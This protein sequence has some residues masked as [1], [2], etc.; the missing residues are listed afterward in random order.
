MTNEELITNQ[1]IH[2]GNHS[3]NYFM[4]GGLPPICSSWWQA[5][6]ESRPVI[7]FQQNTCGHSPYITSPLMRGWICI[8][9]MLALVRA[10]ILRSEPGRTH[11][12]NLLS[13]ILDF[14]NLEGQV[15]QERGGLVYIPPLGSLFFALRIT[16]FLHG[17]FYSLSANHG[18]CW[19]LVYIGGNF[20]WIFVDMKTRSVWSWFPRIHISVEMCVDFVTTL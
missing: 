6:W 19:L 7:F 13:Q 9:Q 12:L 17:R 16:S 4:T 18:K 1:S 2:S 20:C 11:D 10:V 8:L 15:P 14:P 5:P 3:H